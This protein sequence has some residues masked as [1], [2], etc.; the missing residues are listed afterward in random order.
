[1]AR[2]LLGKPVGEV[3]LST[4]PRCEVVGVR[5]APAS[6][7]SSRAAAHAALEKPARLE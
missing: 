1:L 5:E 2:A 3:A 4:A 6:R 7:A